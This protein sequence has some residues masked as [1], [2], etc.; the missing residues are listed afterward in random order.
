MK[1]A[2]MFNYFEGDTVF[3]GASILQISWDTDLIRKVKGVYFCRFVNGFSD[4]VNG[5]LVMAMGHLS[6]I[7][8]LRE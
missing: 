7:E 4:H 1:V 5:F 8:I 3:S 6:P 2:V